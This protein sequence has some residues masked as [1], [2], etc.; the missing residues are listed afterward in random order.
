MKIEDLR[1]ELK[2]CSPAH[3]ESLVPHAE[4]RAVVNASDHTQMKS[5]GATGADGT[6]HLESMTHRVDTAIASR[7][8]QAAV[9][10]SS[11]TI[12]VV[13]FCIVLVGVLSF[14]L[15]VYPAVPSIGVVFFGP[16]LYRLFCAL[17]GADEGYGR[18]WLGMRLEASAP[19]PKLTKIVFREFER[20]FLTYL[21]FL[22]M[23]PLAGGIVLF[24][25]RES[26]EIG[27][28]GAF[29]IFFPIS[30]SL[31]LTLVYG[32]G[33]FGAYK[34]ASPNEQSLVRSKL[35]PLPLNANVQPRIRMLFLM[36]LAVFALGLVVNPSNIQH[37]LSHSGKAILVEQLILLQWA[38]PAVRYSKSRWVVAAVA[39]VFVM[40]L[41]VS[42]TIGSYGPDLR[43]TYTLAM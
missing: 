13:A 1:S 37:F 28:S 33:N 39:I 34:N 7:L 12:V 29:L 5:I 36:P 21:A 6:E 19:R 42:L 20:C 4:A 26:H 10:D 3:D 23:L 31:A 18:A 35:V 15:N 2:L 41:L 11:L 9:I 17:Q 27:P 16:T 24:G 14:I 32:G 22:V 40:P 25:I 8:I 43:S 30:Y 38:I